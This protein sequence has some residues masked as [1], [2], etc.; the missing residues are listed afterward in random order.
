MQ[1]LAPSGS[2]FGYVVSLPWPKATVMVYYHP[3]GIQT[4]HATPQEWN[5]LPCMTINTGYPYCDLHLSPCKNQFYLGWHWVYGTIA[6][7]QAH[8]NSILPYI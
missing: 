2:G 4:E 8:C 6:M 3:S 1:N 7:V 5:E